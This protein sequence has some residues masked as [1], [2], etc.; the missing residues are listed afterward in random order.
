MPALMRRLR[1]R[2]LSAKRITSEST[3]CKW[4][5]EIPVALRTRILSNILARDERISDYD[6]WRALR[7]IEQELYRC[8]RSGKPVPIDLV[9]AR[10]IIDAARTKRNSG[11]R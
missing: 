7:R 5:E 11:S 6:F 1:K 10:R 9:Y 8:R 3:A 4:P 2:T